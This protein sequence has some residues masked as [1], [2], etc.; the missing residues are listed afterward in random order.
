M[1]YMK[2]MLAALAVCFCLSLTAVPAMEA[3]A[4]SV[5]TETV[6]AEQGAV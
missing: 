6:S 2:K 3:Y 5:Q 1:K 4:S